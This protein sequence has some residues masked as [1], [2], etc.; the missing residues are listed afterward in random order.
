MT[1]LTDSHKKAKILTVNRKSHRPI[2]TLI[3][4]PLISFKA[5]LTRQTEVGKLVL[6]NSSWC[7]C[8]NDTKTV[9]SW[10]TVGDKIEL[11]SIFASVFT[12]FFVLV[13]SYLTCERLA[14]VCWWLPTNQNTRY[15]HVI[16]VTS[17]N[18]ERRSSLIHVQ[19]ETWKK[20]KKK[21]LKRFEGR[22]IFYAKLLNELVVRAKGGISVDMQFFSRPLYFSITLCYLFW[23]LT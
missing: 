12:N 16:C 18:G 5:A 11:V 13:N 22:G 4:R 21:E 3:L 17:Q 1:L 7:V 23:W 19:L 8:V 14:N 20:K 2:E 10:K 9:A 6:A 15:I